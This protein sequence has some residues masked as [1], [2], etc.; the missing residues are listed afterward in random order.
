[1]PKGKTQDVYSQNK[2]LDHKGKTKKKETECSEP[3]NSTS[4]VCVRTSEQVEPLKTQ[5]IF[6]ETCNRTTRKVNRPGICIATEKDIRDIT[7]CLVSQKEQTF[8]KA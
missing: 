8:F 4:P 1:M 2:C 5:L 7:K 3:A 6:L